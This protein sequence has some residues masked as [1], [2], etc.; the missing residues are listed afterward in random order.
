MSHHSTMM[1]EKYFREIFDSSSDAIFIQD[2]TTGKV[3]DVN[4][5]VCELYGYEY[6]QALECNIQDLSQGDPPYSMAEVKKHLADVR[7][8]GT[9]RFDWLAKHKDGSLFWVEVSIKFSVILDQERYIVSVRDISERKH[10]EQALRE[11]QLFL[12]NVFDSIQEGISVLD[13]SLTILH[14]NAIMRKWYATQLPLMGQKCYQC[15]QNRDTAC[16]PCPSL[17]CIETGEV[18]MEIR[19]G[20]PGSEA[21]WLEVFGY[22][23]KDVTSGEVI[24]VIEFVRDVTERKLAEKELR[25]LRNY[26][27]NIIDSMPST[28]IAVDAE[29]LV[30]LWN[31]NAEKATGLS[32]EE[33]G[34]QPLVEVLPDLDKEMN[35]VRKAMEDG[36]AVSEGSRPRQRDGETRYENLTVFPLVDAGLEGAVIRIDDVTDWVRI[37]EMAMQ[38]EKMLL[39]AGLAAGIA[40]EINNPLTAIIG[41]AQNAH[42]RIFK[43]LPNNRVTAEEIGVS[44]EDMRNYLERRGVDKMLDGIHDSGNRAAKIVRNMLKFS[45]KNDKD[46]TACDII[47]ILDT[48][49]DLVASDH[50]LKSNY[51]FRKIEIIKEYHENLPEVVCEPTEIQQVFFNLL[52]NGA[53]AMSEK[54]Y[55]DAGPAFVLRAGREGRM[56]VIEIED[57]G[58]GM[59]ESVTKRIFEPFFTT[60]GTGLGTGLGM[61][62]SHFIITEQ[63]GGQIEVHSQKNSGSR[64]VIRLPIENALPSLPET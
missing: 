5:R 36:T 47:E 19:P 55:V 44:L 28:L 3:L 43:N 22:P 1:N 46:F 21:Q 2:A 39:V 61:S 4:R 50:H 40:H 25:R 53:E 48:T 15:Y 31:A 49:I 30:T 29:G 23:M 18:E 24:G 13:L 34:G 35:W 11:K 60:K 59:P 9:Q 52:K 42:N 17:R 20:V 38:T 57:N 32:F 54:A 51:D 41:F 7:A 56:V 45:R 33:A 26:L 63:H 16:D 8:L 27:I 58:P 6:E 37:Q 64:F 62:V 10:A 14:T 12:N